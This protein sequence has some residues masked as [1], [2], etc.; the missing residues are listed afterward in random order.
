MHKPLNI[1]TIMTIIIFIII[2][3]ACGDSN[4]EIS[5]SNDYTTK[6]PPSIPITPIKEASFSKSIT[7]DNRPNT[8]NWIN[9]NNVLISIGK[10]I[11]LWNLSSNVITEKISIHTNSIQSIDVDTKGEYIISGSTDRTVKLWDLNNYTLLHTFTNTNKIINSVKF[12]Y[13]GEYIAA[14]DT[15]GTITIWNTHS[16]SIKLILDNNDNHRIGG[17]IAFNIDS[18]ILAVPSRGVELWDIQKG[19]L[20]TILVNDNERQ[21][22]ISWSPDGRFIAVGKDSNGAI[23]I[24]NV[25]EKNLHSTLQGHAESDDWGISVTDIAWNPDSTLLAVA[26]TTTFA[27]ESFPRYPQDESNIQVWDTQ[28][29]KMLFSFP[30]QTLINGP[31]DWSP[32]GRQLVVSTPEDIQI[33]DIP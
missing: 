23:E 7:I 24:W 16:R 21:S 17:G 19:E 10:E 29:S 25:L 15:S 27:S 26:S 32:N 6:T 8:I 30:H 3:A 9:N 1:Y 31:L 12:S 20:L 33:W 4:K 11:S 22:N 5:N 18:T 28:S 13:D 2:L 14:R